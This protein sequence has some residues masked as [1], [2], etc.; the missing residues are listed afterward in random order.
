M[1]YMVTP[2]DYEKLSD[3]LYWLNDSIVVRFVVS[4]ARADKEN[5]RMYFHREFSYNSKYLDKGHV[6][7]LRRSFSYYIT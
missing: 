7:T 5:N 1:K 3:D 4:L 2:L 6:I